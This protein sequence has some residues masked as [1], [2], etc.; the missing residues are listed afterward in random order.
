MLCMDDEDKMALIGTA[1]TLG[2]LVG[3]PF[4][5]IVSDKYVQNQLETIKINRIYHNFDISNVFRCP[6]TSDTAD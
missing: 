1:N 4:V 6:F 2:R 5:G 3:M